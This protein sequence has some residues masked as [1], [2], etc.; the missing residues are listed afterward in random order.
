LVVVKDA[1]LPA[2]LPAIRGAGSLC[3]PRARPTEAMSCRAACCA[4][5]GGGVAACPIGALKILT[6]T[7]VSSVKKLTR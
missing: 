3:T 5:A 2:F 7:A 1:F 4:A 6:P